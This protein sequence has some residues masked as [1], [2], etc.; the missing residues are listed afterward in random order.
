[1]QNGNVYVLPTLGFLTLEKGFILFATPTTSQNHKPIRSLI[2]SEK[3][4]T[5]GKALPGKYW[6]NL[7]SGNREVYQP[8]ICRND[9][10]VS[11]RVYK[12]IMEAL[13]NVVN[14]VIAK[15][16][17]ECIKEYDQRERKLN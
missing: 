10:R 9:A 4:G 16:L 14:P 15:Y 12:P 11:S 5:H 17:F 6:R 13:G 7:Y 3:N 1:M 8:S 2:P